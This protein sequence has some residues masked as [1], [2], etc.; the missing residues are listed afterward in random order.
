[1]SDRIRSAVYGIGAGAI[2]GGMYVVSDVVLDTVPPFALLSMRLALG[3][4]ALG[5]VLRWQKI[6]LVPTERGAVLPIIATGAV[7]FGVSVGA[8]FVGTDLS[9][10]VNGSLVTSASPAFILLFAWL[11]LGERLTRWRI[12]AVALAT[13]GVIVIVDPSRATLGGDN[14]FGDLALVC[15]AVTWG[16][17]SVLLRRVN[18]GRDSTQVTFLAFFGGLMLI[19][20]AALLETTSRSIGPIDGP[21]VMGILYLGIISTAVAMWMWARAFTL[22]E[23]SVASLYFFAQPLVGALLSVVLLGQQMTPA[24]WLGSFFI[25]LGVLIS[26]RDG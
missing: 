12:I 23:A 8:Q 2:W 9:T 11:I 5:L 25:T 26:L 10:A 3:I 21:I 22:V 6:P 19:F 20:P 13:L 16:L 18:A 1:M 24:L 15:A 4:I 14:F 7:G 17:F